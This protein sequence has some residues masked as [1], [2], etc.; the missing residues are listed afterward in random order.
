VIIIV[1]VILLILG[2]HSCQISSRN[3]A[4][5]D[6]NDNVFSLIQRS[7]QTGAQ[8]FQQLSSGRGASNA[9]GL[10]QQLNQTRLAADGELSDARKLSVPTEM[11]PAQQDVLLTFQMR[12]DG[13]LNI[14]NNIQQ[15]LGTTTSKDAIGTIA[16]EMARFYAS[17]VV[18]KDYAVPLIL[19]ALHSAGL[20][21]PEGP[22]SGQFLPN[23]GWL[24]PTYV[25]SELHAALPQ[26][27]TAKCV[28]GQLVGSA[29]TSV[30]VAGTTLQTGATNT[31]S[32]NPAP[33][34][35]LNF[36]NGGQTSLANV[37]LKVTVQGTNVTGQTTIP[38]VSAGQTTSGNVTLSSP[39]PTGQTLT[40]SAEVVPAHCETNSSNNT[41][42][43]PVTFQ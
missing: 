16:A 17:D 21:P 15:A 11:Q 26:S 22:N 14:A 38:Q 34:F 37:V 24:T 13:I 39:P 25:A 29:L 36:T 28:S 32:A 8:L 33:T 43:F 10:Q 6:Y 31:I 42:T 40:V 18:Y 7:N 3:S 35:T 9:T 23:L 20:Q 2:I 19:G 30:S 5:K 4:L 27:P 12:D 1:V 41:L